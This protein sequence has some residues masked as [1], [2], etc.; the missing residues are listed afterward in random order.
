ML[1]KTFSLDTAEGDASSRRRIETR[2]LTRQGGQWY[3]YSY[4]WN[5][6]Q[7]DAELVPAAGLDRT[8]DVRDAHAPGGGRKQTWH[9]PSRAEC[10]VCHSRAAN[11]VLGLTEMQMNK[12]HDY[13]GVKD[14]QLR[15]LE[16]LGVFKVSWLDHVGEVRRRLGDWEGAGRA[17]ADVCLDAAASPRTLAPAPVRDALGA[18]SRAL[19]DLYAAA[20]ESPDLLHAAG[21]VAAEGAAVHD[22]AAETAG[23]VPPP[24]RP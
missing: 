6:E 1:V 14:E 11:W 3:G 21:G 20:P 16:H 8:Y 7:T 5:D 10:M 18:A 15:T 4:L 19:S 12:V 22:A 2:L 17:L 13:G 23:R 24:P 9:Y